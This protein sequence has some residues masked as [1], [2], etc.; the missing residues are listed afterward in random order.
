VLISAGKK[1]ES[2]RQVWKLASMADKREIARMIFEWIEIDVR[3]S[4][5]RY[6]NPKR[7]FHIF[8]DQHPMLRKDEDRGGY[9]VDWQA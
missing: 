3:E 1:I 8:F 4:K 7:G 9:R 2:F 5:I 6:V